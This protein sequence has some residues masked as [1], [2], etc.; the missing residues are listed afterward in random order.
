MFIFCL[1]HT[2]TTPTSKSDCIKLH[3]SLIISPDTWDVIFFSFVELF[4]ICENDDPQSAR[5]AL[6]SSSHPLRSSCHPHT[7][8]KKKGHPH[9]GRESRIFIGQDIETRAH[10]IGAGSWLLTGG[11]V[12]IGQLRDPAEGLRVL[13]SDQR[14]K[15]LPAGG[16]LIWSNFA[17][18]SAMNFT[19][20]LYGHS[21]FAM[22]KY[23]RTIMTVSYC[24]WRCVENRADVLFL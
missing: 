24:S 6:R 1:W 20:Q 19:R 9:T 2:H 17:Y 13:R 3:T 5:S 15:K 8:Q 12:G 7:K 16:I 22:R 18:K 14:S 21:V 23:I 4:I 11:Y 10:S